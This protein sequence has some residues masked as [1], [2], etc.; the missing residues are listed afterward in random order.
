MKT[1]PLSFAIATAMLTSISAISAEQ[2]LEAVEL[3]VVT[4]SADFRDSNVQELAEAVTVIGTDKIDA[5]NAQHLESVLSL[6]PN[7]NYSSGAS[8]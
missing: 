6:A 8:R 5:R 1:L 2:A 4:V 3:D 7:G